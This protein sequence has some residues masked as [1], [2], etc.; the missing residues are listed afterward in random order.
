MVRRRLCAGDP[1]AGEKE[2][3]MSKK[4]KK[5]KQKEETPAYKLAL[6][7]LRESAI[8]DLAECFAVFC[9]DDYPIA[10][11]D[12][13]YVTSQGRI[14]LN[15]R[16]EASVRELEYV[17]AHCML[18]LGLGHFVESRMGD[19][20]WIRACDLAVTA[21]LRDSKFVTPPMSFQG[22]LPVPA[23]TAEQAYEQLKLLPSS[24]DNVSFSTMSGGRPDMVWEGKPDYEYEEELANSFRR[25][26][27]NTVREAAGLRP[28]SSYD[29]WHD[30]DDCMRARDWF[31]TSYPLL[32]AIAADFRIIKDISVLKREGIR[33]AA[34]SPQL[35]EIYVNEDEDL[36]Q[37]EWKFV[38]AHEFLH[39]ALRH[40]VRCE[41]R[42]PTLWNVACDYVI[43][44]WLREM[45][46]GDMP[47]WVLYD[48]QFRGMT[49][50]AVYDIVCADPRYYKGIAL[51]DLLYGEAEWWDNL[52]GANVDEFYRK[53][54]QQG[55][56]FHKK[57]NRGYLPSDLV[58]EI[59]AVSR[60][61]I[62]WDVQLA[63]WF[64]EQFEPLEKHRTYARMSRRQSATP[65]IPR[66]AWYLQEEPMEQRMFG[67]LLDTSGSMDRSLLA[68]AL[69]SIASYSESRDVNHV[70][71]VFCDAAA[72]DQGIMSPEEIAGKVKVRGRGGT[73]LQPGIDLL[74]RDEKFPKDAPL[75][76]ITDGECDKLKLYGRTHA[77]LVPWGNRLPF[78]PKG[79]V[80]RLK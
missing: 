60:P 56:E 65:D 74:D 12:W 43:N 51:G 8:C 42:E 68:A 17:L 10:K 21:F 19:S 47:D 35:K 66:P 72:Y 3:R 52:D 80:F 59:Y 57:H 64:D 48:E 45:N 6:G 76:I 9:G 26:M 22:S 40:D 44:L 69:G 53:A 58:E 36:T 2:G 77:F 73:V 75:L 11:D 39:A 55:L 15:P 5:I 46:V 27:R 61:P 18:Q 24:R 37:E 23:K 67:V 7:K 28:V 4:Q 50:E 78:V 13:A 70:R 29:V 32:G 54:L 79:P 16:R 33:V 1:R 14:Y 25:S 31:I 30:H 63:K 62:R 71:V 41:D 49:A 34:V 38:L 20:L